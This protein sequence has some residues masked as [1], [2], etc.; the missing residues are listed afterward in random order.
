MR[1]IEF[2]T[3]IGEAKVSLV[4]KVDGDAVERVTPYF[5]DRAWPKLQ[6]WADEWIDTDEGR[7]AVAE[8]IA[9]DDECARDDY[10]DFQRRQRIDD[11]LTNR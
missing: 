3:Y 5:K 11:E 10:A 6:R 8:A 2:D 4:C 9:Y 1:T 7:D